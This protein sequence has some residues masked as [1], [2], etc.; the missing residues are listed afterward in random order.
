LLHKAIGF[1][2]AVMA[3]GTIAILPAS[4]IITPLGSTANGLPVSASAT[5]NFNAG[6]FTL[7]LNNL[8]QTD[9]V[10]QLLSGVTFALSNTGAITAAGSAAHTVTVGSNG[11]VTDVNVS[12]VA[13]WGFGIYNSIQ[14][15]EFNGEYL[16]CAVCNSGTITTGVTAPTQPKREILGTGGGN[17]A[18]PYSTSN[19]SINGNGG[20][21]H[22]P[23]ILNSATFSFNLSSVTPETTA[24]DVHFLFGSEFGADV[25]GESA[26]PEPLSLVL[27]GAGLIGLSLVHRRK[28]AKR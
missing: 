20:N 14:L 2:L 27:C 25:G 11:S 13:G 12:D 28:T 10:G 22:E 7:T 24:Q 3:L 26:A 1:N 15:P 8:G 17:L 5:F 21:S 19:A 23:F 18:L 6:S 16:V 4:T 9:Q